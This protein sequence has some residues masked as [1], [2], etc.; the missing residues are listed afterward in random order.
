MCRDSIAES[1]CIIAWRVWPSWILS[2]W[3]SDSVFFLTGPGFGF[4]FFES[5]LKL[6]NLLFDSAFDLDLFWP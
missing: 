6:E 5:W 4:Q 3:V 1:L 2:F